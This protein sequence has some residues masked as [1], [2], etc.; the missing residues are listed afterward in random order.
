MNEI[1]ESIIYVYQR[2]DDPIR[3]IRCV[4]DGNV[5]CEAKGQV[6]YIVVGLGIP[7]RIVK[8]SRDNYLRIK[9]KRCEVYYS[10]MI[11]SI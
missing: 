2:A 7:A 9:C 3:Y 10:I 6:A 4:E 11:Q 8:I 5:L 1:R